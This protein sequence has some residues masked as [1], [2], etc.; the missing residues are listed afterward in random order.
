MV[1]SRYAGEA[2]RLARAEPERIERM[3]LITRE[4]AGEDPVPP[5]K[6]VRIDRQPTAEQMEALLAFVSV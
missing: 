4:I 1:D 3:A 2:L 6:V 5:L